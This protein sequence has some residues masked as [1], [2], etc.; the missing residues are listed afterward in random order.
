M[1]AGGGGK[2][3]TRRMGKPIEINALWYNALR[4]MATLAPVAG[5]AAEP[6]CKLADK[7]KTNFSKFWDETKSYCYD[8]IDAPG[9]G[10]DSSL[11]PNQ[12]FAVSLPESPLSPAQQK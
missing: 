1:E 11:R 4:T 6:F 5:K 3:I 10:N 7:V 2:V 12:I 9:V 8:V